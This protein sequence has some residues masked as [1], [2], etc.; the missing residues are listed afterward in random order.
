MCMAGSELCI[1][2]TRESAMTL[3]SSSQRNAVKECE[4]SGIHAVTLTVHEETMYKYAIFDFWKLAAINTIALTD[5][6]VQ[7]SEF[8][9]Q[10]V[11]G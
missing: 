6:C 11:D 9:A 8:K 5:V 10:C 7:D 3:C 2:P 1:T 4:D